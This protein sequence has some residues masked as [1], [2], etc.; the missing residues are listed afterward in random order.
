M[1]LMTAVMD[2]MKEVACKMKTQ[3]LHHNLL[4]HRNRTNVDS[5]NS[6]AIRA[7][8]YQGDMFVMDLLI[9]DEV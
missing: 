9:A 2:L 4:R 3:Q 5:M 8:V 1:E 7:F 6:D